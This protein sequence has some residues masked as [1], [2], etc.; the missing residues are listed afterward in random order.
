MMYLK[1]FF[2]SYKIITF[3]NDLIHITLQNNFLKNIII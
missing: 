2:I 3:D 1:V